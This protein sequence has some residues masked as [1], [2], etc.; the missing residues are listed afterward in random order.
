MIQR[1]VPPLMLPNWQNKKKKM[2]TSYTGQAGLESMGSYWPGKA[3][4]STDEDT[5]SAG[6][7]PPVADLRG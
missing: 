5:L 1:S 3:G 4:L 2:M 6:E 7:T